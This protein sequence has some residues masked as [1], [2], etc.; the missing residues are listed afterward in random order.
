MKDQCFW[1][2]D[3][4]FGSWSPSSGSTDAVAGHGIFGERTTTSGAM[5]AKITV[6]PQ[7]N[8]STVKWESVNGILPT[9]VRI[10]W[11]MTKSKIVPV[12]TGSYERRRAQPVEFCGEC[13]SHPPQ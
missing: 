10:P 12:T 7:I 1:N 4:Y 3:F 13:V 2:R 8:D 6:F 9:L 11:E 5:S